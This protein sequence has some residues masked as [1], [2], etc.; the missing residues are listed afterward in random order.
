MVI[1]QVAGEDLRFG[2]QPPVSG[3]VHD[4]IAIA[5]KRSAVR[6]LSLWVLAPFGMRT[7]HRPGAKKAGFARFDRLRNRDP[8]QAKWIVA[9]GAASFQLAF[10]LRIRS[11][12]SRRHL[13]R[14]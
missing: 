13:K 8:P 3:A 14:P 2:A 5:L 12:A 10:L 6:M 1:A 11:F 7:V 4:A 9:I